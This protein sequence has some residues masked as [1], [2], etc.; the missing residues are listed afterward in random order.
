MSWLFLVAGWWAEPAGA[1]PVGGPSG[2][3]AS[4]NWS[5]GTG[6]TVLMASTNTTVSCTVDV[7]MNDPYNPPA[8][9]V[10]CAPTILN[11]LGVAAGSTTVLTNY[12]YSPSWAQYVCVFT[13]SDYGDMTLQVDVGNNSSS[14]TVTAVK[15]DAITFTP[16]QTIAVSNSVT[17]T[18]SVLPAS[19]VGTFI[20]GGITN[21]TGAVVTVTLDSGGHIPA[22]VTLEQ[23]GETLWTEVV[24][25]SP[26]LTV[27]ALDEPGFV[28]DPTG[29][30]VPAP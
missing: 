6:S 13:V 28:G 25:I 4:F 1:Q 18:A 3:G 14:R 23:T 29:F 17:L 22:W 16:D 9:T 2:W 7:W 11:I 30:G 12:D 8:G 20:W 26:I 24:V 27:F 19:F 10:S 21:S 5:I 15:L